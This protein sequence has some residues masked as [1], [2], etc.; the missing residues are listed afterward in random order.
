MVWVVKLE[1]IRDGKV[2]RRKQVMKI[3]RPENVTNVDDIGL[4]LED[5]KTLLATLQQMIASWQFEHNYHERKHCPACSCRRTIKDYRL[6]HF[7]TVYGRVS[8]KIPR[9]KH[10]DN[11]CKDCLESATLS[12]PER[13]TSEFNALRAKLAAHLSFRCVSELLS[14]ILPVT[15]GVTHATVR[16]HTLVVAGKIHD[17]AKHSPESSS[18]VSSITLGLDTAYIRAVGNKPRHWKVLVGHATNAAKKHCFAGIKHK[19][20]P[21][22]AS[23]VQ[24]HL[25]QLGFTPNTQLTLFT[26]GENGLEKFILDDSHKANKPILDWFHIAMRLQQIRQAVKGLSD[27]LPSHAKA[28]IIIQNEI[29]RLRWRLWHG[30]KDAVDK[31]LAVISTAVIAYRRYLKRWLQ[32]PQRKLMVMIYE[33]KRYIRNQATKITNYHRRHRQGLCVSTALTESTVNML[34]NRRM[35]KQQQMRWSAQGAH[36]LLIVRAAVLNGEFD[37]LIVAKEKSAEINAVT[38]P[39]ALAA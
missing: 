37:R 9:F 16:R 18:P 32:T 19:P 25:R 13:S 5:G 36:L 31:S 34:V 39:C 33:L 12:I 23:I 38:S 21:T 6:R 7:D 1:E 30:K 3:S 8:V 26:D 27:T 24:S 10:H 35:N 22:P 4:C 15:A 11:R 20:Q 29:E 14:Q 28:K 2:V 17:N